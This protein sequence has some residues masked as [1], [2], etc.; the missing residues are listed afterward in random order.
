MASSQAQKR[1]F[2]CGPGGHILGDGAENGVVW[3]I[4]L[5][6]PKALVG[7]DALN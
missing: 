5:R 2:S 3:A 7:D 4:M 6:E 1:A